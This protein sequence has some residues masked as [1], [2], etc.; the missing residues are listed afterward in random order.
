MSSSF[1][2]SYL[3]LCPAYPPIGQIVNHPAPRPF[4]SNPRYQD[5]TGQVIVGDL[6]FALIYNYTGL[7]AYIL[8][9]LIGGIS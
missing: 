9:H 6:P 4:E 1:H 2:H 5:Y 8:W 3:D 7:N